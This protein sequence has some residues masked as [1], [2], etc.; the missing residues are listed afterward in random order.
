MDNKFLNASGVIHLWQRI[1]EKFASKEM[2]LEITNNIVEGYFYNGS[3][4]EENSYATIISPSIEK[5]YIDISQNI[6]YRYQDGDG[7]IPLS[8]GGSG[9]GGNG[10]LSAV[11]NDDYSLTLRFT[12]GTSYTTPNIRGE[13][14][15]KGADGINGS[16]IYTTTSN[17]PDFSDRNTTF[18]AD[19]SELDDQDKIS[20]IKA[21]DFVL[22]TN[23][24]DFYKIIEIPSSGIITLSYMFNMKGAKGETG[25][26]GVGIK[27][28]ALDEEN[29]TEKQDVY[30]ITLSDDTTYSFTVKH[31]E[32]GV[33]GST[34]QI[35]INIENNEW[36]VSLDN[37]ITWSSLNIK[38]TGEKGEDGFTPIIDVA[39]SNNTTIIT[40]TDAN[41][42]SKSVQI[43]DGTDGQD[44]ESLQHEWDGT[45]LVITSV[46]GTSSVD[47]K[48][49]K[50]DVG[51]GIYVANITTEKATTC[52]K[53]DIIS[54]NRELQKFD[55]VLSKNTGDIYSVDNIINSAV[56]LSY[57]GNIRG[58]KGETGNGIASVTKTN[59]DGLIDTYTIRFTDNT[60]VSFQITNGEQGVQGVSGVYVGSGEIPD[61]YNIQ[62]DPDGDAIELQL[63]PIFVNTIEEL[64]EQG[65]TDKLYIL[66]DG[67]I[68]AYMAVKETT[69]SYTN[70]AD[71][72]SSD[73]V[74]GYRLSSTAGM[75]ELSGHSI[76][77][78]IPCSLDDEI[79]IKNCTQLTHIAMYYDEAKTYIGCLYPK[80]DSVNY[81]YEPINGISVVNAGRYGDDVFE[82]VA[83]VRFSLPTE[84]DDVIITVGQEI[85]DEKV[86]IISYKWVNTEVKFI[87]SDIDETVAQKIMHD[88]IHNNLSS[89]QISP[90]FVSSVEECIDE[91]KIYV[92]P[93]G[94]I[95]KY[96]EVETEFIHNAY[97]SS[98]AKFNY[99]LN[100]SAGEEKELGGALLLDY[101]E[102]A[103]DPDCVVTI[104]GIEKLIANYAT[105]VVVDY[106][107]TSKN[108]ISGAQ[109]TNSEYGISVT[110]EEKLL[111]ISFNIFN[112]TTTFDEIQNVGY[113]RIK[114]GIATDGTYISAAD[115]EGL[116]VNFS[117]KNTVFKSKQ[118]T[119]TGHAFIP[120]DYEDRIVE[121]EDDVS[122]LNSKVNTI[123]CINTDGILT[124][125]SY[126]EE[127]MVTPKTAEIKELLSEGG[128]DCVCFA[129]AS[130][131]HIPDNEGG[132][133]N[134]IGRV[135]AKMLDNCEIP[136]AVLTGDV[137]TRASCSTEAQFVASQEHVPLHLAPLWGTDRLLVAL[138][139]HDG[140]WGDNPN[141]DGSTGFYAHQFTPERMWQTYFRGQALD[142]RR[143]FSD[144][145]LY[146]YVDNIAQKTRFIVLNSQFGGEYAE[147]E[148]G[149]AV[150]N[151]F[152]TSC[153]GQAQLDWLA[154]IALDMPNGYGAVIVSHV[155][156]SISYT[157]DNTQ[158]IGIINAYCNKT[159][160]SGDYTGGVDGW[161]NSSVNVDFTTAQGEIIAMFAGHV[162]GDSID[163]VTLACPLLT[164]LSAGASANEAYKES[165]PTRE[166]ETE[167][168]TS[169]DVVIINRASRTIRCIR[170]GAGDNR[171]T[172]PDE[173]INY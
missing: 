135:I 70:L 137:G 25:D 96:D 109:R 78:F 18:D 60:E 97:D 163:T 8:S 41:G 43:T 15:E 27:N 85:D 38:A 84:S 141:G 92:L 55:V 110:G 143:V 12:D 171:G 144:D 77:N 165:A 14:G 57:L 39:K 72:K 81:S 146:F 115:C 116:T 64:N 53:S 155:P 51:Y 47:L 62:I 100:S 105:V 91:N 142:F 16:Y 148:N 71:T 136:F 123:S 150:N 54:N 19:L 95:Y 1:V 154:N 73:W 119:S 33:S 40:I 46:K 10:I 147:D 45:Y 31:G 101:V 133:T 120:T 108:W 121:L 2:L 173:P 117:T 127:K 161:S 9:S 162:H 36:E 37:G 160:F 68:Y 6:L 125:P 152:R 103:Y 98:T 20:L 24:G 132:R 7:Y 149:W 32:N 157:V 89:L 167:T 66:P 29:S 26:A 90:E 130:D 172:D 126:W 83:Y 102:Q 48:G 139:N 69:T 128:K 145:G 30:I 134:D 34:P 42:N 4:Y 113:V 112:P 164:I 59:T 17:S 3:F 129:W 131:T 159:T 74:K 151:R 87:T 35:R 94:Y 67:Y 118:W 63:T 111:P 5:I 28:I 21:G 52:D 169:F 11:L 75:T 79:R 23:L 166:D 88:E 13:K 156:P 93:D 65:E 170:I 140:C 82:D 153:Y 58:I 138:G 158:L 99:R 44:G 106:F 122:K 104:G 22:H 80:H 168:E 61:G 76:S 86:E 49:D 107:D 56:Y 114:L 50:G 124:I